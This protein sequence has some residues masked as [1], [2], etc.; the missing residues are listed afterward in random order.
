MYEYDKKSNNF[1]VINNGLEQILPHII[2]HITEKCNLNC[3]FC[4]APKNNWEFVLKYLDEYIFIFKELGIQKIDIAGG[5]PLLYSN[6][7]K[8]C[9]VLAE[10]GFNLTITTSGIGL[11]ENITWLKENYNLFSRVIFSIDHYNS[12]VHDEIRGKNGAFIK[13]VELLIDINSKNNKITRVNTVATQY[14]KNKDNLEKMVRFIN[15]INPY[16]WCLIQPHPMNKKENFDSINITIDEF[17]NIEKVALD[18]MKN[19]NNYTNMM[20]RRIENYNGYWVLNANGEIVKVTDV[21]K[22]SKKVEL[23]KSNLDCIRK[24]LQSEKIWVS[25]K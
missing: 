10:S 13:T 19:I 25:I 8:L 22:K 23:K 1:K 5:E 18:E 12:T 24:I 20:F 9:T 11:D 15:T 17:L 7:P 2:W 14:I 4:F 21:P 16:E 6:L 3:K